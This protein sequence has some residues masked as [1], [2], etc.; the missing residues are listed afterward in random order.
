MHAVN[1]SIKTTLKYYLHE[2]RELTENLKFGRK[3]E[4]STIFVSLDIDNDLRISSRT[5]SVAVAVNAIRG[6]SNFRNFKLTVLKFSR[7]TDNR[8]KE[9]NL[10]DKESV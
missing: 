4:V 8:L 5:L 3:N 2:G 6:I 10:Y 1:V 7:K 9:L